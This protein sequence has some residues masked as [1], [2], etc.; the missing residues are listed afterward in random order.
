MWEKINRFVHTRVILSVFLLSA[1]FISVVGIFGSLIIDITPSVRLAI[2]TLGQITLSIMVI[3]LMRKMQVFNI[4]DFKFKNT[5]KSFF[6]KPGWTFRS[7]L[8]ARYGLEYHI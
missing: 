3:L 8:L 6:S 5:G 7:S 4:D 2:F 1:F